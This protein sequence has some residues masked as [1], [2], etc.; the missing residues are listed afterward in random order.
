MATYADLI[1]TWLLTSGLRILVIVAGSILLIRL[2][3]ATIDRMVR[4]VEGGDRD[5]PTER[6]KRVR[7]LGSVLRKITAVV[8]V[9]GAVLTVLPLIG[10]PDIGGIVT[11]AGISG[12]AIGFGAQNL[13]RDV[14]AGFFMLLENQLRVGD[15]VTINRETGVVE[16]ITLRTTILRGGDGTVHVFPNGGIQYVSNQTKD[17]SRAFIDVGVSYQE[18]FD[19]VIAVLKDVAGELASD[20]AFQPLIVEPAQVLGL[21]SFEPSQMRIRLLITTLP[22]KHQEV[23]RE[24]RRRIKNRFDREGIEIPLPTP[25]PGGLPHPGTE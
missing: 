9:G 24:L 2:I 20:P 14:I 25:A 21:E 16:D 8:V 18:N 5:H 22:L 3:Y 1:R 15:T 17:W 23:A 7:T 11:I 13:I 12:V 6:E 19:R 4:A 10:F